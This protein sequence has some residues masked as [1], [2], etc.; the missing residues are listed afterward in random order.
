MKIL[1]GDIVLAGGVEVHESPYDV[2]VR[3]EREVQIIETLR[4]SVAKSYDH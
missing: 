3:S 2:S 1:I 4:G